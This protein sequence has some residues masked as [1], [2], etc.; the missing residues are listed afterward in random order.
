MVSCGRKGQSR[1]NLL[2]ISPKF[3]PIIGGGETYV[4]NSAKRLHE[5]GWEISV[6]IEPNSKRNL[7]DYPFKVYEL[8]GLS[9]SNLNV[10]NATSSLNALINQ[11]NPDLIHAH[12]YFA[13]LAAGLC[14][15]INIP[16][17]ALIHSTPVWGS[18]IIGGMDSFEAE[19]DFA[20]SVLDLSEPKLLTAANA[21]YAEAAKK[22]AEG[23]VSVKVLPYP[24]DLDFFGQKSNVHLR[25][26]MGLK[27][28]DQLI[29]V[30]SR[31]IRRKGIKEAIL[32]LDLIPDNFYLCILGA[33]DP[34][35][36]NYW[37]EIC[38]DSVFR[39]VRDRVIV[40]KQEMLYEDMPLL[41]GACNII[42]MPSYY[43]GAPVATV[44]AM[45]SGKA[46]VGADSQGINSF[47]RN[48]VNGLL[49]PQENPVELAKA[50]KRLAEDPDLQ[51]RLASQ[52]RKDILYLSWSNQLPNL[53]KICED[54]VH[55][56]H[57]DF[58]RVASMANEV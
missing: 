32:A 53:V 56:H 57:A 1:L 30:P 36:K 50:I 15:L 3:H 20:R 39:K 45:A 8:E 16:I 23:R 9:D 41:Y 58:S 18:R 6:A 54:I 5:F 29:V 43:E 42:A 38:S 14:N 48:E 13:L 17:L 31:V 26:S 37:D 21:V 19:L 47:I 10:I 55:T 34:L 4:L 52:A 33:V 40:P 11:I 12:G 35:D 46:F 27:N 2:I 25:R 44:E 22:I 49:V 7:K 51:K 28:D 24:V